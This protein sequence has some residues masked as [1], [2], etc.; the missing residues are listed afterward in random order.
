[1]QTVA[2]RRR[3]GNKK[4]RLGCRTC[5]ARHIKCD[6]TPG[7]CQNCTLSSRSC[8]YDLER[9]PRTRRTKLS[10]RALALVNV[11][12]T[13]A[14]GLHWITTADERRCFSHF[15]FHIIPTVTALFDVSLW[16][17]VVLPTSHV[18]PAVYHAAVALSA[19]YRDSE[20]NGMPLPGQEHF[21]PWNRFSLEQANRSY[22]LV[23]RRS[24]SQ[25]PRL[26]GVLLLCC[27]LFIVQELLRGQYDEAFRH[28]QSGLKILQGSKGRRNQTPVEECLVAAFARLDI[29]SAFYGTG[30]PFMRLDEDPEYW[31]SQVDFK[32]VYEA[33]QALEPLF[34]GTFWFHS[35]CQALSKAEIESGYGDLQGKQQ[36]LL[37]EA[38][39]YVCAF[40]TF[41]SRSYVYLNLKDQ[42]AA[43]VVAVNHKIVALSLKEC[44]LRPEDAALDYYT[45]D[46]E[47][48]LSLVQAIIH[49]FPDRPSVVLDM[50]VI[51]PLYYISLKC[52]DYAV[53]WR[54]IMALKSWPHRE[55]TF[56]ANWAASV[57]VRLLEAEL[58]DS[59]LQS[60]DGSSLP[61]QEDDRFSSEDAVKS[62]EAVKDWM[63][64]QYF[65]PRQT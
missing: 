53:R 28:L 63:C 35:Q 15:Q 33:R 24:A 8:E 43:D 29:Q 49:K 61:P 41:Y 47:M 2:R 19:V 23:S 5:R 56:D 34:S 31:L 3:T 12:P 51:P 40:D 55:G 21:N 26:Q 57:A 46:H 1:M 9:L 38:N 62:S 11:P 25:D 60:P 37:S 39:R 6:E 64:S 52:R 58:G 48:V 22:A 10:A 20:T 13:L 65:Q 54:A 7:T 45:P 42:R 36:Q 44:L 32:T 27:L 14:G 59:R 4:S 50:G 18:E 16:Q 30:G 17:N